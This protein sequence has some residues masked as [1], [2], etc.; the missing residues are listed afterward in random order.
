MSGNDKPSIARLYRE[1]LAHILL[2][3]QNLMLNKKLV[4]YL[5]YCT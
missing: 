4:K 5:P 2:I 1:K 3:F